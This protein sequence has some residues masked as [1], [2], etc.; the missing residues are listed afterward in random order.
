MVASFLNSNMEVV[1]VVKAKVKAHVQV[2]KKFAGKSRL[3]VVASRH[4]GLPLAVDAPQPDVIGFEKARIDPPAPDVAKHVPPPGMPARQ[5]T[6][7]WFEAMKPG[8]P[9]HPDSWVYKHEWVS[10]ARAKELLK[11]SETL[12]RKLQPKTVGKYAA[13]VAADEFRPV[14]AQIVMSDDGVNLQGQ[15]TLHGVAAG[16]KDVLLSI[17][18]GVD[19]SYYAYMDRGRSRTVAEAL[20]QEKSMVEVSSLLLRIRYG[21]SQVPE[22]RIVTMNRCIKGL[23]DELLS[24]GKYGLKAGS[25]AAVRAAFLLRLADAG[26]QSERDVLLNAYSDLA[27]KNIAALPAALANFTALWG[28]K[29]WF[30]L[31]RKSRT[32]ATAVIF[33]VLG[34]LKSTK[35][36]TLTVTPK[37]RQDMDE[38]IDKLLAT[39]A[40]K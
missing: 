20:H 1:V 18:Y 25:T 24:W 22:F 6:R 30:Q 36:P 37:S 11:G 39:G 3:R 10:P 19:K 31:H 15:H 32:D 26:N 38:V 16:G 35:L 12:Q 2:L 17:C 33:R 9:R 5:G 13:M 4:T 28:K 8:D 40:L 7:A 21:E 14:P 23:H 29:E 34:R 27:H